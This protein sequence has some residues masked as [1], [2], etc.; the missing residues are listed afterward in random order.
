MNILSSQLTE[1][2][3]WR[4]QSLSRIKEWL[5]GLKDIGLAADGADAE[6]ERIKQAAASDRVCVVFVAEFSRGKSELI[7][8][9]FFS[10]YGQRVVPSGAGRT[11]MCPTEFEYDPVYPPS[12][13]LLPIQTR[14]LPATL[15]DL[16]ANPQVWETQQINHLYGNDVALQLMRVKETQFVDLATAESLGLAGDELPN[17]QAVEIPRWRHAIVNLPHPLLKQ[18][19]TIIDTPGL[20]ALGYEPELTLSVLPSANAV[21]YVLAADTG[22][23][24]SDAEIWTTLLATVPKIGRMVVLNKIDSMWDELRSQSEIDADI[25]QQ[26]ISVA[27]TLNVPEGR[28]F[29]LS[30]QKALQ[31]RIAKN[32]I[33]EEKS[34]IKE[35]EI[36]LS[37]EVLPAR[38]AL[39]SE[40]FMR[41][42]DEL[43][44]S[45]QSVLQARLVSV[46]A[47][48][49]ELTQLSRGKANV[50]Q[51][52][53][54]RVQSEKVSLEQAL[55]ALFALRSVV[56]RHARSAINSLSPQPLREMPKQLKVSEAKNAR[57]LRRCFD[58]LV[59]YTRAELEKAQTECRDAYH[60]V[61][62]MQTQLQSQHR[63][64][65]PVLKPFGTDR[66]SN[67]IDAIE[68]AALRALPTLPLLLPGARINAQRMIM[69]ACQHLAAVLDKAG[70]EATGWLNTLTSPLDRH[71]RDQQNQLK[72]R[73]ESL[74]RMSNAHESLSNRLAELAETHAN[75]SLQLQEL[76]RN[77]SVLR[78]VIK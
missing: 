2:S 47:Q 9:L 58:T 6:L 39:L 36:A 13:R 26:A 75:A 78:T 50:A 41:F 4:S 38:R 56:S 45:A 14:S 32:P 20:N 42:V 67:E 1:I 48:S 40:R 35:L 63:L 21:L 46:D 72:R 71:M 3:T 10:G 34:R 68:R 62:G 69:A 23:T 25:Y 7:N 17:A 74:N 24:K 8:A 29:A 16:K 19:L 77:H 27:H 11:T 31:S 51:S 5:D 12:I 30:A 66:Y 49:D 61:Q 52:L 65:L 43:T 54:G 76:T 15:L 18:G 57:D 53:I 33:L 28:V 73:E 44:T 37:Q 64:Q 60:A 55:K 59:G 70:R 22:V